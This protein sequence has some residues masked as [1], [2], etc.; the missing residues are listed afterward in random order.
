MG[1]SRTHKDCSNLSAQWN[2]GD[3]YKC[4]R[5]TRVLALRRMKG[6][7]GLFQDFELAF[8]TLDEETSENRRQIE[9]RF[10]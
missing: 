5:R 10:K 4:I 7:D 1:W 8:Q 2:T 3:A 6:V 9:A